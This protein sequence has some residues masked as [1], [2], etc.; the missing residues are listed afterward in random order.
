MTLRPIALCIWLLYLLSACKRLESI[1]QECQTIED[2]EQINASFDISKIDTT[3]FLIHFTSNDS[4]GSYKNSIKIY[5]ED[6]AYT[7]QNMQLINLRTLNKDTSYTETKLTHE[8]IDSLINQIDKLNCHPYKIDQFG[9][10]VDGNY[11]RIMYKNGNSIK[12]WTWGDGTLSWINGK[13]VV[14]SMKVKATVLEGMLYRMTGIGGTKIVYSIEDECI[15]DSVIL[16]IYPILGDFTT[17]SVSATH[18]RYTFVTN[19]DNYISRNIY[20][21]DSLSIINEMEVTVTTKEN[22]KLVLKHIKS[23]EEEQNTHNDL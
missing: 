17:A 20:C 14:D 8:K 19:T 4:W 21:K 2:L 12:G 18:P 13:K 9:V 3:N 22:Q 10:S 5:K 15:N 23:L 6:L 7:S 1:D 16:S 11:H